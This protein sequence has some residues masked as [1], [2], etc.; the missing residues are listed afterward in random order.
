MSETT[1]KYP[2]DL[3]RYRE[4]LGLTQEHLVHLVRCRRAQTICRK[5]RGATMPGLVTSFRLSAALRGPVEFL[6]SQTFINLR[7]QVRAAEEHILGTLAVAQQE[8]GPDSP[9]TKLITLSDFLDDDGRLN[10]VADKDL[11]SIALARRLADRERFEPQTQCS[12]VFLGHLRSRDSEGLS[13]SRLD[14]VEGVLGRV[15][16]ATQPADSYPHRWNRGVDREH[17]KFRHGRKRK[18]SARIYLDRKERVIVNAMTFMQDWTQL[19]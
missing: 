13:T 10:L 11:V 4:R 15:A 5:E 16:E 14:A 17:G 18:V 1:I 19:V 12:S 7:N 2:N 8:T 6:R 9:N 3:L